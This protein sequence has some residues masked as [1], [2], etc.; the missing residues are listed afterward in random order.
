M[1]TKKPLV[2]ESEA[3]RQFAAAARGLFPVAK[4][5]LARVARPCGRPKEC[6]ACLSGKRHPMWIFAFRQEGR[7]RC[8]YVPEGLVPALRQALADGREME[9]RLVAEGA[10]MIERYRRGRS[11]RSARK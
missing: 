8:L 6:A 2:R 11:G 4:G 5:S 7:A 3:R 9:K 1:S 10:A